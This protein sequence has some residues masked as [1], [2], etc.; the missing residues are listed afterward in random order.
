MT[1]HCSDGLV[2]KA[3]LKAVLL[4]GVLALGAGGSAVA[5]GLDCVIEPSEV[6]DVS[7]A[8]RGVIS[9]VE[10]ERGDRVEQGQVLARIEASVEQ[11]T[12]A[13]AMARSE[14]T[15]LIQA[16]KT[17]LDLAEK[18][19]RRIRELK[20][21]KAVASQDL[22]EAESERALAKIDLEQAVE[23]RRLAKLEL[24]RAQKVLELRTVK[25]P[26][27]GVVVEVYT[28]AGELTENQPIMQIAQIDP[29]HVEAIAPV[30]LLGTVHE[31]DI[32][33]VLPE[34]PVGG[35]FEAKVSMVERIVDAGSGTFGIQL[36]LP[37]SEGKLPAGLRCK[38]QP[39]DRK[40]EPAK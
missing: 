32:Y 21:S 23:E 40:Q 11:A 5:A 26:V 35:Q 8:V 37:N 7:S 18:R 25:S 17:R 39:L 14:A 28:S 22:D 20:K 34:E 31:G 10:V 29:L 9:S 4:Y 13:L 12:V 27:S 3:W 2:G 38:L 24:A 1:Y 19:L 36:A 33:H 16:R 15:Q 6:A 30:Q